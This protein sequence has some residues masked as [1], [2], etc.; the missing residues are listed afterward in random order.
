MLH[1]GCGLNRPTAILLVCALVVMRSG[2]PLFDR[3]GQHRWPAV[4]Y[5]GMAATVAASKRP[6]TWAWQTPS[7]SST[8][9][10]RAVAQPFP[11]VTRAVRLRPA[12]VA[13]INPPSNLGGFVVLEISN[14]R[15]KPLHPRAGMF[16]LAAIG[17]LWGACH[18]P[19]TECP[20]S[21]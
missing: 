5:V 18:S 6:A 19:V 1:Q 16:A 8:S 9:F 10:N 2:I 4:Y 15:E 17:L 20:S 7:A 12:A 14:L 21:R 11:L 13:L 3:G